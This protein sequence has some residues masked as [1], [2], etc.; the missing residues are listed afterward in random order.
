METDRL[1]RTFTARRGRRVTALEGVTLTVG[2][3]EV[4]G[5][6]GPNG[7]GK[8]TLSRILT[9]LLLPTSGTARVAGHDVVRR[10][11]EVR[12]RIGLVLG[13]DRGL[14]GRLT[15]RQNLSYWAALQGLDART[16][17]RRTDG[18]LERLGLAAR[19]GDRVETFS[20]GMVQRVHLARALL[21][22]PEVLIMDEPTNGMDPHSAAGFRTLVRELRDAGTTVLLTTHDMHEAQALCS[23][24][25]LID[26]GTI[27]RQGAADTLLAEVSARR[28]VTAT[29]VPAGAAEV[30]A[31]L[32]GTEVERGPGGAVTVRPADA[33][34]L[35]RVLA[36]LVEARAEEI[37]VAA[38]GLTEV[39]RSVI[40]DRE[41]VV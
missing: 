11:R 30:L 36:V 26:H 25:A 5:L 28:T 8:T 24:L 21:G 38:P 6:L 22:D 4:L 35:T 3:G 41:F 13:G 40:E 33:E 27:L 14:Y 19:A 39:Y 15:A 23:H 9:T 18:L 37:S 29:G 17:A 10:P 20:R 34:T 2:R 7:A 16:A 12:R 31:G 32:P 1:G